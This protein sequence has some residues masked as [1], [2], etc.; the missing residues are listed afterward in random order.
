MLPWV[1]GLALVA[2]IVTVL[3]LM[4]PN[5]GGGTNV[6]PD[7]NGDPV[8]LL[9]QEKMRKTIPPEARRVA[10]RFVLTAAQRRNL[11]EA[12][13]LAGPM[14]RQGMTYEQ[15]VKGDIAAA[16]VFGGIKTAPMAVDV[17]A[18]K[19][20]ML[21]ILITPKDAT[22]KPA[23]Y[24]MRLDLIGKGTAAHWVVNEFQQWVGQSIPHIN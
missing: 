24:T 22:V 13:P 21:Q 7:P 16:R 8:D 2:G 19:W 3:V 17:A 11:D 6:A 23:I 20:A 10:G 5:T 18:K 9:Q 1:V 4:V 12:W 14:V 15:W